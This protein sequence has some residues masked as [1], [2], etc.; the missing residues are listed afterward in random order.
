MP[1]SRRHRIEMKNCPGLFRC[2][3]H[4]FV[5]FLRADP[6]YALIERHGHDR[7]VLSGRPKVRQSK[8]AAAL[9]SA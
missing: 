6:D 1:K 7:G 9:G 8:S 2:K 5:Y 3:E 4:V